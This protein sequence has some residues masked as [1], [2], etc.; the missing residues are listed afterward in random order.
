MGDSYAR[1]KTAH[2]SRLGTVKFFD[3]LP[4]LWKNLYNGQ[5][6][7]KGGVSFKVPG[8]DMKGRFSSAV[9]PFVENDILVVHFKNPADRGTIDATVKKSMKGVE[10]SDRPYHSGFDIH[11]KGKGGGSS[12]GQLVS[13]A[14]ATA[15]LADIKGL[16]NVDEMMKDFDAIIV[17]TVKK[18]AADLEDKLK[19]HLKDPEGGMS[20]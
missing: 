18:A 7:L 9:E 5:D 15:L 8:L 1:L 16:D 13:R 2:L 14:A 10:L 19:W 17:D 6:T 11:G 3:A 4:G 20:A 12:F